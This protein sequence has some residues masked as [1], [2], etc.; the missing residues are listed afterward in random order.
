MSTPSTAAPTVAKPHNV[1]AQSGPLLTSNNGYNCYLVVVDEWTRYA[2]AFTLA[3]K[4]PPIDTVRQFLAQ[5]GNKDG[6]R[7]VRTDLGGELASSAAFRTML[8]ECD[9]VL[10]TTA[11]GS[12][13]QMVW[14]S[15]YIVHSPTACAQ[16]FMV[17]TFPSSTELMHYVMR[18]TSRIGFCTNPFRPK[19]RHFNASSV[20]DPTSTTYAFLDAAS[21]CAKWGA[22]IQH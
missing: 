19:Q 7:R 5:F 13:F 1:V 22:T 16:C 8:Q 2:W 20:V 17:Q 11:P 10:K 3:S 4:E 9:Y 15:A 18:C 14:L 12:S 6:L 21:L